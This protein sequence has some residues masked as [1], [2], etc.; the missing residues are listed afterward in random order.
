[1]RARLLLALLLWTVPTPL[2]AEAPGSE[3]QESLPIHR[4]ADRD[5]AVVTGENLLE[6]ERFWPYHVAL[7]EP[8]RPQGR[9]ASLPAGT[10]GVLIRVGDAGSARVDFGRNG[11]F[12]VPVAAT[13]LLESAN[14]IRRGELAKTAPN[15]A[16]AIGAKL[17]DSRGERLLPFGL[18]AAMDRPG[19]LCVFA[20][21]AAEGFAELAAALAPLQ[22]RRRVLT[23]LFPEGEHRDAWV[24]E[25]VRA[26]GWKVPFLYDFLA[27]SFTRSLL[28]ARIPLPA[29]MLQTNEGRVL[30][31]RRFGPGVVAEL[32][33]AID[34]AFAGA[35]VVTGAAAQKP[36]GS[37]AH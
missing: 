15:L 12:D 26:L 1:M 37:S 33:R 16:L 14:R 11:R 13:D 7:V 30:I 20:D 27:E 4:V 23:V 9:E 34:E 29:V 3:G 17:V 24:F 10:R 5:A 21:P 19:F 35:D 22:D 8:W 6:S 28:D 2:R 25:R 18:P 36:S 31:E 32:E